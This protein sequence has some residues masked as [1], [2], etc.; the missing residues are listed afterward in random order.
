MIMTKPSCFKRSLSVLLAVMMVFGMGVTNVFAAEGKSAALADG[1]YR[2]PLSFNYYY[3]GQMYEMAT[4]KPNALISTPGQI[5]VKDGKM[6]VTLFAGKDGSDYVTGF[7][8]RLQS[9]TEFTDAQ[10]SD[11]DGDGNADQISFTIDYTEDYLVTNVLYTSSQADFVSALCFDFSR[12]EL[13]GGGNPPVEEL[14]EATH[15]IKLK[16]DSS[17]GEKSIKIPDE[18]MSIITSAGGMDNAISAYLDEAELVEKDGEYTLLLR[19]ARTGMFSSTMKDFHVVEMDSEDSNNQ[20]HTAITPVET[21]YKGAEIYEFHIPLGT[22]EELGNSIWMWCEGFAP[23][24]DMSMSFYSKVEIIPELNYLINLSEPALPEDGIYT[25]KVGVYDY[26]Q[27]IY[28]RFYASDDVVVDVKDGT[29]TVFIKV[30]KGFMNSQTGFL[31]YSVYGRDTSSQTNT[32][33]IVPISGEDAHYMLVKTTDLRRMFYTGTGTTTSGD[34]IALAFRVDMD[35]LQKDDSAE[36]MELLNTGNYTADIEV[37]DADGNA[38]SLASYFQTTAVPVKSENGKMTVT[39]NLTQAGLENFKQRIYTESKELVATPISGTDLNMVD[40]NLYYKGDTAVLTAEKDGQPVSFQVKLKQ[41]TIHAVRDVNLLPDGNYTVNIECLKDISNDVSMSGSYFDKEAVSVKVEDEKIYM[42]LTIKT[43]SDDGTMTNLVQGLKH[44]VNGAWVVDDPQPTEEYPDGIDRIT[45]TIQIDSLEE[46]IYVQIYVTAMGW[47]ATLRIVPDMNTLE[48]ESLGNMMAMPEVSTNPSTYTGMFSNDE[49]IMVTLSTA[50]EAADIYYTVDGSTPVV[51]TA[52]TFRYTKP[53]S[54]EA[55]SEEMNTVTVKAI[56]YKDGSRSFTK[57]QDIIFLAKNDEPVISAT[58]PGVYAVP[59]RIWKAF[60]Q[61]YSMADDAVDGNMI[62]QVYEDED[63]TL[64]SN[65]YMTVKKRDQDGIV[66]HL[67]QLWNIP[68]TD[69]PTGAP[70]DYELAEEKASVL[71]TV[72][73]E[74]LDG[75]A[76]DYPRSLRFTRGSSGEE[77]FYIRVDVDAMGDTHQSA[78]IVMDWD[79]AQKASLPDGVY[80]VDYTIMKA[81]EQ[82][83]SMAND[84]IDGPMTVE[85]SNGAATYTL[86]VKA[87]DQDGIIGHLLQLWNIPGTDAPTGAPSD[88][89]LDS[90]LAEI[91]STVNEEGFDGT[92]ANYGNVFEFTRDTTGEDYFYIRVD[93]DAMGNDHQSAKL[94]TDWSTA[95]WLS[96]ANN[97]VATPVL[98]N[99]G[100]FADS[101]RVVITCATEGADIYYT[102]DGSVPSA[103]NGI[104]YTGEFTVSAT[105]TVK[106]I[107]VKEGLDDSAVAFATYTKDSAIDPDED[108]DDDKPIVL[109]PGRYTTDVQL[110]HA[111]SNQASMGNVAFADVEDMLVVEEN[112]KYVLHVAT[113]PVRVS[114][115]TTAITGMACADGSK[116]TVEETAVFTTNTKY[117]GTAHELEYIKVFSIELDSLDTEYIGMK[118][119]VPYTHMDAVGAA[120]DGWLYCRL[121][122]DLSDAVKV[123]DDYELAPSEKLEEQSPAVDYTDAKTGVKIHA[124]KGVFEEGVQIIVTEIIKG[125]DYDSTA[126]AL[127]E[128]GKKFKLYDVKFLDAQGNEVVP[129]G[130]VS[131]SLPITAGYDSAN[132]AVYRMVDVGKVLVKGAVEDGYYTVI[133]RSAGLY[134]LVEKDSTITDAQNTTNV[135][136]G[137][138]SGT[139]TSPQT[140]DNSNLALWFMLML[141]SAGILAVLTLTGKRKTFKGE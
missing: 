85:I 110:W 11:T 111:Y 131:I 78:K 61:D 36:A 139:T 77:Y 5:E 105:T 52:K 56:T 121:K 126:S 60:E 138:N 43:E 106:A 136:D 118:M 99:S 29:A 35:S 120:T 101:M 127:N 104:K 123:S 91:L 82:D 45:E 8:Y 63:G 31:Y 47:W 129:N 97:Q 23:L 70:S 42:T 76:A 115:Y 41:D 89:E 86:K 25:G 72:N 58:E 84:V 4:G 66:G 48:G 53:F 132:L 37:T 10:V 80:E 93:V 27:S 117:D 116:V 33:T 13:E 34:N 3:A 95:K 96:E 40:V 16:V 2:V 12:A 125:A 59:Y 24:G 9:E 119:K 81:F 51:G 69:A 46:P 39:L 19:M 102:V 79:N 28:D 65:Y 135:N 67:L 74:G 128:V 98:T 87:R 71:T 109:G 20:T 83:Y 1:S 108:D 113:K 6:A 32:A 64:K 68:G 130:T 62:V 21:T 75:T 112:G 88:Y 92:K 30:K 107:A 73:E 50:E 100:S 57:S 141:A 55:V 49:T 103:A 17:S 133:T 140:G 15:T 44:K 22:K 38:S 7:Q 90:Q 137:T 18:D 54:V 94:V 14:G 114:G 26:R 122:I 124:D 134:T